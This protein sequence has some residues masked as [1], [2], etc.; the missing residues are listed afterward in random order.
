MLSVKRSNINKMN[1]VR[2]YYI[3]HQCEDD[4]AQVNQLQVIQWLSELSLPKQAVVQRLL[5]NKDRMASLLASRLLKMAVEQEGLG[6]FCLSDVQYPD[7]GKPYWKSAGDTFLDFNISHSDNMIVVAISCS[8]N[9]GIDVERVRELKRL[10]FKMVLSVD[11]LVHIQETPA[12]F[13]ELWSKKEAVVKA[14]NTIGVGRMREVKI[15]GDQATLGEQRW[16]LKKLDLDKQ[17]VTHLATSGHVGEVIA[18]QILISEL[19]L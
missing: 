15:E 19:S 17:Y 10:N 4:L 13:F 12:L 6:G 7:K 5:H 16:H 8:M 2:L 11:E 9:V 1:S 18:K 3:K 14:A